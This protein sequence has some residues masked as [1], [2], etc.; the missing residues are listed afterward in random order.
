M[1]KSDTPAAVGGSSLLVIFAVLC[2]TIFA[3]LSLSTVQADGRLTAISA[4]TVKRYYEADTMA[5][6]ILADLRNGIVAEGVEQ[7]GN[8]YRYSCPV[9][10]TQVLNVT[11]RIEG[12]EVEILQWQTE[13]CTEWEADDRLNV[14]DGQ[15]TQ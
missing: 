14:W 6:K 9:S 15:I 13:S 11:V 10:E 4:E 3:L 1:R 12:A 2:L 5:E 8:D 7:D